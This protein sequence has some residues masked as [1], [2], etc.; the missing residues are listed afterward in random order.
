MACDGLRHKFELTLFMS[1]A[2]CPATFAARYGAV[3]LASAQAQAYSDG[4]RGLDTQEWRAFWHA[5]LFLHIRGG[6]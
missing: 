1:L 3:M 6:C 2:D 5:T 4:A